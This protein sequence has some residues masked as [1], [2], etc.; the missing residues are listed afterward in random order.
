MNTLTLFYAARCGLCSSVRRWLTSQPA[1]VRLEFIPYDA[2]EARQRCPF[3]DQ[4]HADQE[5]V[6]LSDDGHLWQGAGAWV[7]CLWALHDFR[8]WSS[9]L[10]SPAMRAIAKRI[11]QL[12]SSNRL[13]LSSLLRLRGDAALH[14]LPDVTT[15]ELQA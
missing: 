8:E 10:A 3:I 6:V 1:Y 5:I 2:P 15:C 9:R 7:M 4:L 12:I 13:T 11:V 14:T